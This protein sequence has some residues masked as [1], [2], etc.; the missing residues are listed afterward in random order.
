MR[1]TLLMRCE[2]VFVFKLNADDGTAVFPQ[3]TVELRR[4]L[5][6]KALDVLQIKRIVAARGDHAYDPLEPPPA[7]P[8]ANGQA[9]TRP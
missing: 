6:E 4:D 8:A 3:Q 9:G 2:V 1:G 5:R 7:A